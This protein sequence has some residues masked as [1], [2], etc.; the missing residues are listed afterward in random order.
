MEFADPVRFYLVNSEKSENAGTALDSILAYFGTLGDVTIRKEGAQEVISYSETP[1]KAVF[2]I[3]IKTPQQI[4]LICEKF[5]NVT[6]SLLKNIVGKIG[7]RIFNPQTLSFMVA[8]PNLVDLTTIKVE[9][10][11]RKVLRFY[12]LKPLFF[13]RDSLVYYAKGKSDRIHLVNRHL[14]D[15]LVT[16]KGARL[17]VH[18]NFSV[19]VARDMGHFI[20]LYDRGLIPVSFYK[21]LNQ[22]NGVINQSGFDIDKIIENTYVILAFFNFDPEKQIFTQLNSDKFPT[23][24]QLFKRG[25]S[26]EKNIRKISSRITPR[27][28][29]LGIKIANQ[30]NFQPDTRGKLIPLL[31][32]SLFLENAK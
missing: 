4:C 18:K 13:Y 31:T 1:M 23:A 25:G 12:K 17:S 2:E 29:I 3:P 27:A 10:K 15:Y 26:V 14:L 8:D 28:K 7:Y 20:A 32:V 5:D 22:P 9:S 16:K 6:I 30:V 21:A 24:P 19:E 11:I